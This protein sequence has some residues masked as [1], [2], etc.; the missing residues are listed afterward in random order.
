MQPQT[1]EGLYSDDAQR[2]RVET[3]HK[4]TSDW[5]QSRDLFLPP[6][7]S[8]WIGEQTSFLRS[9]SM[10]SFSAAIVSVVLSLQKV[11]LCSAG[12]P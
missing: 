3:I 2:E 6:L 4:S 12:F 5:I 8:A 11:V 10:F 1:R 7:P 9:R